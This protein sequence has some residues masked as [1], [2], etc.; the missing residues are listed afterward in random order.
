MLN[1]KEPFGG[2]S[3]FIIGGIEQCLPTIK[4]AARNEIINSVIIKSGL[5]NCFT[6]KHLT[7]NL[8]T[9]KPVDEEDRIKLNK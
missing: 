2:L 5:F 9:L 6:I 3:V 8:R 1:S 4:R 7:K